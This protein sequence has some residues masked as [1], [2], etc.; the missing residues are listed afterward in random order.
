VGCSPVE[1]LHRELARQT[2]GACELV[3][4]NENAADAIVRMFHR[5][6]GAAATDVH[7]DWCA[8]AEPAWQSDPPRALYNG[9]TVHLF[10]QFATPPSRPPQ[11]R[12]KAGD[13]AHTLSAQTLSSVSDD[14]LPRLA[15]AKRLDE[16]GTE[17]QRKKLALRYQLISAQT[18]LF[19]VHVRD[20]AEKAGSLPTLHQVPQML[21]A[22][23]GGIGTVS[24]KMNV[25]CDILV[26]PCLPCPTPPVHYNSIS[27]CEILED[28]A[29]E[30]QPTLQHIL[31]ETFLRLA[32]HTTD[33]AAIVAQLS[34]AV[35]ADT[36]DCIAAI[37]RQ[38]DVSEEDVWA[39]LLDYL[40]QSP[41]LSHLTPSRQATRLLHVRLKAI[42]RKKRKA[43]TATRDFS[44]LCSDA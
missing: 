3:S 36:I 9:E 19:L 15:G 13:A 39:V 6:R 35:D 21:A 5:L 14:S 41:D 43:I 32:L 33:F 30:A 29:K 38:T 23:W 2:G 22:G 7:V 42:S 8:D 37:A 10:A 12:W 18:N 20:A 17:A 11:L 1:T 26:H 34:T 27:H 4:P 40:I 16:T 31:V 24:E 25:S 44:S 28:A